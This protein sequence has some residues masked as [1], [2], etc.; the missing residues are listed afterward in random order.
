MNE[1]GH[2]NDYFTGAL[3]PEEMKLFDQQIINDPAFAE[4]VAFYCNAQ[5]EIKDAVQQEKKARFRELHS[6]ATAPQKSRPVFVMRRRIQVAAAAMII[7]AALAGW[8]WWPQPDARQ[9]AGKYIDQHFM[10]LPNTMGAAD[11]L[12]TAIALN[13]RNELPGALA[14]FEKLA[15]SDSS[16]E[17]AIKNAGIVSLRM[18]DYDKALTYFTRLEQMTHL[19]SNPGKFYKAV[20]LLQRNLPGDKQNA[21]QLLNEVIGNNLEN[22]DEATTLIKHL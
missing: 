7:L 11:S 10:V 18:K 14:I 4:E 8:L 12:Q 20:T 6:L 9:L 13:N 17:P 5:H 2:I 15:A 3:S 19:Y 1:Y 22:K 16:N 21:K